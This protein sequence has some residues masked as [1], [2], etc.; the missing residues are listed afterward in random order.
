LIAQP[1]QLAIHAVAIIISIITPTVAYRMMQ[2]ATIPL[3][4]IT[5]HENKIWQEYK[6]PELYI[7]I[8]NSLKTKLTNIF[9]KQSY[10]WMIARNTLLDEFSESLELAL[11]APLGLM[12]NF[13]LYGTNPTT[14]TDKQKALPPILL[15]HGNYS[16]PATFLPLLHALEKAGNERAVYTA[17]LPANSC[18]EMS[19]LGLIPDE[20]G[21]VGPLN[22]Y[23]LPPD[24]LPESLLK[25]VV[26]IKK[27]HAQPLDMVGH[28]MGAGGMQQLFDINFCGVDAVGARGITMGGPFDVTVRDKKIKAFD[29][30]GSRD[31]GSRSR[32]DA[33]HSRIIDTGHCG[34]LFHPDSLQ[35][36]QDFLKA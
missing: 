36:V 6:N 4:L 34:L 24:Y 27:I 9:N 14:L 10:A 33:A 25:K 32:L 1:L 12:R 8:A 18:N 19:F 15:L 20:N 11:V 30:T 35:A 3:A 28:S 21:N 16:Y 29:I 13:H 7:K 17:N 31:S 26:D 22:A 2:A 5:S 23:G